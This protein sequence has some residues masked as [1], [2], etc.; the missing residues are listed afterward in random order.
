MRSGIIRFARG[1][2]IGWALV[3]SITLEHGCA[4]LA[5]Q[6][7]GLDGTNSVLNQT[8]T[9]RA[10]APRHTLREWRLEAKETGGFVQLILSSSGHY[11]M[12]HGYL[13]VDQTVGSGKTLMLSEVNIGKYGIRG[14]LVSMAS[15]LKST[16]QMRSPD[17]NSTVNLESVGHNLVMD[18]WATRNFIFERFNG[19]TELPFLKQGLGSLDGNSPLPGDLQDADGKFEAKLGCVKMQANGQIGF[20][21]PDTIQDENAPAK[22]SFEVAH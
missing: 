17:L 10:A 14:S 12:R 9:G 19:R 11:M 16:C 8:G 2:L 20:V 22:E 5:H 7:S 13:Y 1:G 15:P 18:E 4:S 6:K 3:G 21:P